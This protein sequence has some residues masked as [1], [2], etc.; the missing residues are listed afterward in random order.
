MVKDFLGSANVRSLPLPSLERRVLQRSRIGERHFPR[1][2]SELVH[3]VQVFGG[4]DC[5]LAA[6]QESNAWN[7]GGNRPLQ[8]AD[9]PL[10]DF[11]NPR[12]P[13]VVL[14]GNDHAWL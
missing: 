5:A 11:V 13:R 6:R 12:L 10:G 4:A 9:G 2:G 8:A 3:G 7:R 1:K 14:T